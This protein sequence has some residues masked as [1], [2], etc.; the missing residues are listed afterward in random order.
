MAA[1]S[2]T[3]AVLTFPGSNCDTDTLWALE[4]LGVRAMAHWY[5][6]PLGAVDRV[7]I[8]GGFSY[9][10]YLRSGALAAR[11]AVMT[12]VARRVREEGLPVLG[13]CNGFQILTEA[14]L[15]PG[16]L[17]PNTTGVFRATLETVTVHTAP[18]GWPGFA[19]QRFRLP[20]AHHEGAFAVAEGSLGS[21]FTAGEVFLQYTDAAGRPDPLANPNG[22]VANIAGVARGPVLGL[23]PHPE[24]AMAAYLGSADGRRFLE[25]WLWGREGGAA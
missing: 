15:L 11:S 3:V 21:L 25:L 9:G 20:V 19:G 12:E 4:E 8:P 10:D 16:A 17:R 5:R 1:G 23:M 14:G 13:I 24:R 6:D 22:A 7:I 18:A 2:P